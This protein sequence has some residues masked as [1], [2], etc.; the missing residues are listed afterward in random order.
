MLS[1]SG[2]IGAFRSA[3]FPISAGLAALAENKRASMLMV[4]AER[5]D[6]WRIA[7]RGLQIEAVAANGA[8]EIG[9]APGTRGQMNADAKTVSRFDSPA[10]Q[11]TGRDP[12][13]AIIRIGLSA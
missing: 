4:A 13:S 11:S 12:R 10:G 3:P 9:Q 8:T 5:L 1:P 7:D 2:W 6:E